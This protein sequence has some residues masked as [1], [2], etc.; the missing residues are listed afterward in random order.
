MQICVLCFKDL[1]QYTSWFLACNMQNNEQEESCFL[2]LTAKDTKICDKCG[3][4]FSCQKHLKTHVNNNG[5]C[6]PFKVETDPIKGML[7]SYFQVKAKPKLKWKK[8]GS[9]Q[10][11]SKRLCTFYLWQALFTFN[12]T[13]ILRFP[14]EF[15]HVSNM[16]SERPPPPTPDRIW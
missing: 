10:A 11:Q 9:L 3:K 1:S 4:V 12:I 6:F 8:V 16:G 14:S 13:Q 5:I 7:C 2:C 15:L